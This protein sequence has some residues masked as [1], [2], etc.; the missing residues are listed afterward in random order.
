M[1]N[2]LIDRHTPGPWYI[3]TLEN[4]GFNVVHYNGGDKFDIIRV[5]K[6]SN[7]ADAK[8]IAA[9]PELLEALRTLLD[10][11][12]ERGGSVTNGEK[13]GC[14]AIAKATQ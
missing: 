7:E 13:L 4:F 14:A 8:L 9:A 5:A 11:A 12:K 10:E 2:S 3:R 6:C 1:S